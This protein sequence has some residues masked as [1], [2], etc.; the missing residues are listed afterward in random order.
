MEAALQVCREAN[1][2]DQ[3]AYINQM[4]R[5]EGAVAEATLHVERVYSCHCF[6]SIGR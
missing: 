6:L 2:G 1:T 5:C 4:L 3:L